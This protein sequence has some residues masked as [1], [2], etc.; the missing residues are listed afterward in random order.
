MQWGQYSLTVVDE[1]LQHRRWVLGRNRHDG[2]RPKKAIGVWKMFLIVLLLD[3]E[4]DFDDFPMDFRRFL[5]EGVA[6]GRRRG[7]VTE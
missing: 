3:H 6:G 2:S 7:P 1:L 5:M 4:P